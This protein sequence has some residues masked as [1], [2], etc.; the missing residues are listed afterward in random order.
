[1]PYRDPG[2]EKL[3][4][5]RNGNVRLEL[6]SGRILDPNLDE[7]VAVRWLTASTMLLLLC[8]SLVLGCGKARSDFP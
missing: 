5:G 6:Q 3:W 8:A 2:G 4:S 1:M 7:V